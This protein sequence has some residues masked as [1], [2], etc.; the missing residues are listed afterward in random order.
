VLRLLVRL[1]VRGHPVDRRRRSVAR[2]YG[3][4]RTEAAGSFRASGVVE[5]V[6]QELLDLSAFTESWTEIAPSSAPRVGGK[7]SAAPIDRGMETRSVLGRITSTLVQSPATLRKTR[8][9]GRRRTCRYGPTTPR[10]P[11]PSR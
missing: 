2:P 3:G 4:R 5:R 11:S 9:P 1:V 10:H 7:R 6:L 8:S